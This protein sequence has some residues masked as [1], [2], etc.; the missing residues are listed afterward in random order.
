MGGALATTLRRRPSRGRALADLVGICVVV[1]VVVGMMVLVTV[2]VTVMVTVMVVISGS[3]SSSP[4]S[5]SYRWWPPKRTFGGL[6]IGIGETA[7]GGVC[8]EWKC[9][10]G[11]LNWSHN[12]WTC[13]VRRAKVLGQ[14]PVCVGFVDRL[15]QLEEGIVLAPVLVLDA[16]LTASA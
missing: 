16:S 3:L 1:T 4:S 10:L 6:A 2:R 8:G 5:S 15:K 7:G 9:G 13:Q 14:L 11:G 12:C